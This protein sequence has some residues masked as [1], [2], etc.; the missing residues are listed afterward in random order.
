MLGVKV[1]VCVYIY[2]CHIYIYVKRHRRV[3]SGFMLFV[4]SC[5][6]G[7]PHNCA[8]S[9][10]GFRESSAPLLDGCHYARPPQGHFLGGVSY[11][12]V[13]KR[14]H[15]LGIVWGAEGVPSSGSTV[16]G[17]K[18]TKMDL[19]RPKWTILVSQTLTSSS[20]EGHSDQNGRLDHFGPFWS[21]TLSDSTAAIPYYLR[22][23]TSQ[24]FREKLKG[25]N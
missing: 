8:F 16:G 1:R 15:P 6:A 5:H 24:F 11:E 22:S 7:C 10:R 13:G 12:M 9:D 19:F 14:S 25:N 18:C 17:P 23:Q 4:G 20:E 21:S 2:I 3:N